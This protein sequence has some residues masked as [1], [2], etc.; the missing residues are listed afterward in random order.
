M[1]DPLSACH[2]TEID[3]ATNSTACTHEKLTMQVLL[4]PLM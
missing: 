2:M 4:L 1:L 3:V